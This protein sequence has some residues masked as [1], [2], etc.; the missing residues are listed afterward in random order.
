MTDVKNKMKNDYIIEIFNKNHGYASS[1]EL[2]KYKIY[3]RD[4]KKALEDKIIEKIKQGLFKLADI[5]LNENTSLIEACLAIPSGVI[6]LFSALSYYNLTTQNPHFIDVAIPNQAKK[7][8]ISYPPVTYHFFRES[9]YNLGITKIKIDNKEIRIY[10]KEKTI[11]DCFKN[12]N[13][14][15]EEVALEALKDYS[16]LKEK[17]YNKLVTYAK[18]CKVYNK[19]IGYLKIIAV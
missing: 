3:P 12:M 6:C 19:I 11:C 13:Y 8:N 15:T 16:K 14:V 1:K 10:D 7:I 9:T 4:I 17:D 18:R 2:Y 5:E